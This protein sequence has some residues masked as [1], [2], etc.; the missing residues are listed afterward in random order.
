MPERK[1]G[2]RLR[3]RSVAPTS[4]QMLR[5]IIGISTS[6]VGGRF[7]KPVAG[8]RNLQGVR[9][10]WR[11]WEDMQSF[12]D[13]QEDHPFQRPWAWWSFEKKMQDPCGFEAGKEILIDRGWLSAAEK[14]LLEQEKFKKK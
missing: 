10:S 13:W 8:W 9:D 6:E 14:H 7:L 5:L 4:Q 2:N 11:A 12:K 3:H 1:S